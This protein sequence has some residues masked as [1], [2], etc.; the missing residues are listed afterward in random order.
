M[1]I[2]DIEEPGKLKPGA[3]ITGKVL[4][5][6]H[7]AA[8]MVPHISVVRRPGAEVVYVIDGNQARARPVTTGHHDNGLVE[9]VS[10]LAGDETIAAE[11]AAFLT[12]G[13][14]VKVAS[15]NTGEQAN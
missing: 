6:T 10:G 7:K 4:V 9:I 3:T 14:G 11:G 5:D 2:T 1:T 8:V 13:A 15:R 12:D